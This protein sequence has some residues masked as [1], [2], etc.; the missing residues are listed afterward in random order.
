MLHGKEKTRQEE[1]GS[2]FHSLVHPHTDAAGRDEGWGCSD[3]KHL[4]Q[5]SVAVGTVAP[6]AQWWLHPQEGTGWVQPSYGY[7]KPESKQ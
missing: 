2:D 4:P 6:W 7:A 5:G 1:K 3:G